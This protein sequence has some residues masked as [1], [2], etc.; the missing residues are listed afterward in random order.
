MSC[1]GDPKPLVY[2]TRR[3]PCWVTRYRR[4]ANCGATSKSIAKVFIDQ[5]NWF[6]RGDSLP[7]RRDSGSD[8]AIMASGDSLTKQEAYDDER[9][10]WFT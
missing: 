6:D 3:S 8:V 2:K 10:N 9:Y 7:D 1:C 4:C 5:R